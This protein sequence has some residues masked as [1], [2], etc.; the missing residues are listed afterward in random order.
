M[1]QGALAMTP[2]ETEGWAKVVLALGVAFGAIAKLWA[3]WR[4]LAN[5]IRLMWKAVCY[6]L[7]AAHAV[8][9]FLAPTPDDWVAPEHIERHRVLIDMLRDEAWAAD[10]HPPREK[11][12]LSPEEYHRFATRT[13]KIRALQD[14]GN[15]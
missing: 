6:L 8:L 10:G 11:P 12:S 13:M 9:H 14:R 1:R 3:W 7:D 15:D 4:R 5:R 2:A